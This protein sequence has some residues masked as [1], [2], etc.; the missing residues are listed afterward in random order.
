MQPT[1]PNLDV[2]PPSPHLEHRSLLGWRP[3]P[4]PAPA[5]DG[6]ALAPA[7]GR[8][9]VGGCSGTT[10][11]PS[12][13]RPSIAAIVVRPFRPRPPSGLVPGSSAVEKTEPRA[14]ASISGL[15]ESDARPPAMKHGWPEHALMKAEQRFHGPA[16]LEHVA[17]AASSGAAPTHGRVV[18]DQLGRIIGSYMPLI[19]VPRL[20]PDRRGTPTER[21]RYLVN[22][23][24][25][26]ARKPLTDRPPLDA[27][28][29]RFAP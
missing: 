8:V 11:S 9:A 6:G 19:S 15:D 25:D 16:D 21:P 23:P 28:F 26:S 14:L 7:P 12:H 29:D 22:P 24:P 20:T 13:D 2:L 18:D 5:A 27:A 17:D 1:W 4:D 10:T 3:T